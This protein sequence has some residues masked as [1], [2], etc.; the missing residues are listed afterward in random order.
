[1]NCDVNNVIE[2]FL[3]AVYTL[4]ECKY[5]RNLN[6]LSFILIRMHKCTSLNEVLETLVVW[7]LFMYIFDIHKRRRLLKTN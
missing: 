6:A 7:V 1:M 3:N 5:C 4:F 2:N